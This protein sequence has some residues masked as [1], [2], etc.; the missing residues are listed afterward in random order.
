MTVSIRLRPFTYSHTI[1]MLALTGRG[2]SNPVDLVAFIAAIVGLIVAIA[3]PK[4][5]RTPKA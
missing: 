4:L 1:G 5:K 2:F 3:A